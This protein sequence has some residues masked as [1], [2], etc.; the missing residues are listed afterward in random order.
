MFIA[1]KYA[2]GFS[3]GSINACLGLN[4][5]KG[6]GKKVLQYGSE[7]PEKAFVVRG[8]AISC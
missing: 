1:L 7:I 3:A 6:Q 4:L 5:M 2:V 8:R